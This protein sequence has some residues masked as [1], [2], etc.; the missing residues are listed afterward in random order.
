MVHTS[1]SRKE[2]DNSKYLSADSDHP[3][4]IIKAVPKIVED[5]I[6]RLCRNKAI[7]ENSKIEYDIK[8]KQQGYQNITFQYKEPESIAERERKTTTK[9]KNKAKAREILWFVPPFARQVER[10]TTVGKKFFSILD[11]CFPKNHPLY[12]LINR[13]TVKQ[14]YRTMP[15]FGKTLKG[16]NIKVIKELKER[17]NKEADDRKRNEKKPRGRPKYLSRKE[18]TCDST[19]P[20]P[21]EK[22]CNQS[23]VIY[24]AIIETPRPEYDKKFYI[25][26]ASE[27]KERWANHNYTFR[28]TRGTDWVTKE[29]PFDNSMGAKD[30]CELC[31]VVGIFCY[32][33]LRMI[34]KLRNI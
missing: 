2:N 22:K 33:K 31:E 6:N 23:G 34:L 17:K 20:C 24:K 11:S 21:L 29:S 4:T 10:N 7:F 32:L 9:N 8:L 1:L 5:R 28:N 30:S 25:G 15:N 14:S 16:L 12:K 3:I 26:S 18:C 13:N 27:F 19:H